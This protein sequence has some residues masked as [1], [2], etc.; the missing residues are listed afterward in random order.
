[1]NGLETQSFALNIYS[2]FTLQ[3]IENQASTSVR[4]QQRKHLKCGTLLSVWLCSL[5]GSEWQRTARLQL[6]DREEAVSHASYHQNVQLG[7]REEAV[8]HASYHQNVQLG[9]REEA[10]SHASY[11]Q[12]DALFLG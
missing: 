3:K 9:D 12:N 4:T 6:G 1:M 2:D 11:H 5:C 10:V 8:S 7:D